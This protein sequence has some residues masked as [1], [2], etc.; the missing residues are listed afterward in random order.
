MRVNIKSL[1]EQGVV[2]TKEPIPIKFIITI[3][4]V[5]LRFLCTTPILTFRSINMV[6]LAVGMGTQFL[7]WLDGF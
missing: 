1:K 4:I 6:F 5:V 2:V 7:R 3:L